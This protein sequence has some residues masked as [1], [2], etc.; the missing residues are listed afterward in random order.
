MNVVPLLVFC[1]LML[2]VG[3]LVLF[4]HG[5]RRK[6]HHHADRLALLPIENDE[7][8]TPATRAKG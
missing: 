5:M 6:D 8:P 2:V 3:S 7:R 1:S 4:V